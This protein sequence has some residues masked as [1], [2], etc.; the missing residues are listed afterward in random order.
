MI[1][2][3][4]IVLT[5]NYTASELNSKNVTETFAPIEDIKLIVEG[6]R[7]I[8]AWPSKLA[9]MPMEWMRKYF[10]SVLEREVTVKQTRLILETQAALVMTVFPAD[11]NILLRAV[12]LGWFAWCLLK[13]KE[14][15]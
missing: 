5:S 13:C 9:S 11:I 10:S 4:K 3:K 6:I 7:R 12:F 1:M 15:I 2:E 14:R 8:C